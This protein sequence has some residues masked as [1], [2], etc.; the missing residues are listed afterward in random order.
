MSCQLDKS[1][2]C[3]ERICVCRASFLDNRSEGGVCERICV[4][5]ASFLDNRFDGSVWDIVLRII[6]K[7]RR[8]SSLDARDLL[9]SSML[10]ASFLDRPPCFFSRPPA[11][12]PPELTAAPPP[13][14]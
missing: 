7:K 8:A 12:R 13:D 11:R 4:V 14:T 10:R 3:F 6:F 9:Q 5:R 1:S 2:Q